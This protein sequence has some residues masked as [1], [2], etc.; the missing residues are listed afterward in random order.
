M[1]QLVEKFRE[2]I[3]RRSSSALPGGELDVVNLGWELRELHHRAKGNSK[4][5]QLTFGVGGFIDAAPSVAVKTISAATVILALPQPGLKLVNFYDFQ[6]TPG[7]SSE[8]AALRLNSTL[9]TV[10]ANPL[11]KTFVVYKNPWWRT[12]KMPSSFR[13][14]TD[15]PVRQVYHFG[16]ERQCQ[17]S[18]G[19]KLRSACLLLLFVDA[20]YADY[21]KRLDE[22]SEASQRCCSSEFEEPIDTASFEE[23]HRILS[24]DGTS[25]ILARTACR[26]PTFSART[27]RP[28]SSSRARRTFTWASYFV[29]G[30]RNFFPDRSQVGMRNNFPRTLPKW[31]TL[32]DITVPPTQLNRGFF[33]QNRELFSRNREKRVR[34]LRAFPRR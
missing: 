17:L 13:V 29:G 22:K 28:P 19:S 34:K 30:R 27:I 3:I 5:I 18:T 6:I 15:L 23:F 24:R 11:F 1:G 25:A 21:W 20:R 8:R 4:F 32:V 10:T 14:F 2:E 9:D 33:R 26:F 12:E 31:P 7:E 16:S